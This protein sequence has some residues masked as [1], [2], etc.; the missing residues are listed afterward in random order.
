MLPHDALLALLVC[1]CVLIY[2]L[3][4]PALP[5]GRAGTAKEMEDD[6]NK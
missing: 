6:E 3:L 5:T 4:T 1:G 2:I